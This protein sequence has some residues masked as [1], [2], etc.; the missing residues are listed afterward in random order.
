MDSPTQTSKPQP[1]LVIGATGKTG[2]RV[3]RALSDSGHAVRRGSRAAPTPFDWERPETWEP[4]LDGARAAYVTYAPDLA[5]PGAVDRVEA[6]A[7]AARR[8]GLEKLVLL[9]GRGERHARL[10]EQVVEAS[11]VAYTI[12]RA[13]WFAQNFSEGLLQAPIRAGLLPAPQSGAGDPVREPIIDID[14]IADVA[15]AALTEPGHDGRLYEVTGPELLSFAEMAEALSKATGR[16]IAHRPI[17]Y[18]EFHASVAATAGAAMADIV[19]AIARETLDGRNAR[20]GDGVQRA[21]GR[22]PRRFADFASKAAAA[23]AWSSAAA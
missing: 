19:T 9:S 6:L 23:G 4:A 22:A 7:G 14:D 17:S 18:A 15:V 5:V 20:L 21:L 12:I 13:A 1:I 11:G 8:A 16:R 10:G 3:A 2:S